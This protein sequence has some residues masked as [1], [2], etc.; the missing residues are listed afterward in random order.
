[1]GDEEKVHQA[2]VTKATTVAA[3]G[4]KRDDCR[5]RLDPEGGER[6]VS[7]GV[8]EA[9]HASTAKEDINDV[10]SSSVH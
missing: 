3:A 7:A 6:R 4:R 10:E 5:G 9:A 8:T 1:M 2:P